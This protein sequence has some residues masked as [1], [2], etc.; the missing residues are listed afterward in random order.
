MSEIRLHPERQARGPE[1]TQKRTDG[2][3]FPPTEKPTKPASSIL[4]QQHE[5]VMR[6]SQTVTSH[7]ERPPQARGQLPGVV[8]PQLHAAHADDLT[9]EADFLP[10]QVFASEVS[11]NRSQIM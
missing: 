1:T 7:A 3:C 2:F 9:N 4:Q 8:L 5:H 6:R 11:K 10:F